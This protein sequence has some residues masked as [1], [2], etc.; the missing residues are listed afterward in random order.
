VNDPLKAVV[1]ASRRTDLVASFPEWLASALKSRRAAVLGPAGGAYQVDLAPEK[2]HTV[3]LWS[4]DF[5]N[6]LRNGHRLRDRL[7]VYD[8][9][10]LHFTVTGLGGSALEPG[11]PS[12]LEALAQLPGLIGIAG[13]P[14]RVS[15]RF[16]PVVFWEEEGTVRSNLPVF[17]AVSRAAASAGLRDIRMSFAQWYGKAKRRAAA[18]GLAFI[19]PPD[20]EKRARA[21]GMAA[22]AAA[23]GLVLHAC[24]QQVLAGVPG[25]EPS[26]SND[27][28]L[29]EELHPR[30]EA[31]SFRKDRGQRT[32]CRC[33]ESRDIGSYSQ[34]CPHG[35]V[36]CYA[37]PKI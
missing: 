14:R 26:A 24:C 35:C 19:D 33:T 18:R 1:S 13:D 7:A 16:D 5:G 6:L 4:K 28:R 11:A 21:A 34:A 20:E 15:V 3:V 10:Y 27:G 17:E 29:H 9:I 32:D 23:H 12:Y 30:R 2:V 22:F 8:Q 37:N 31:V 25:L 36:Y